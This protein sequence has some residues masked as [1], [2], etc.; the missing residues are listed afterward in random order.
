MADSTN[1]VF[2][3]CILLVALVT[4]GIFLQPNIEEQ[5]APEPEIAWVGIQCDPDGP[6]VVGPIQRRTDDVPCMLHAILEA[7]NRNDEPVYYTEVER[8]SFGDVEVDPDRLRRWRR[9]RWIKAR[10]FTLEGERPYVRLNSED[11]I[12]GF[13]PKEFFRSDW[14]LAWSIP[15]SVDAANDNHLAD[16]SVLERQL[17][18]TQ[19]YHVRVE[20]YRFEDDLLPLQVVRSWGINDLK[21]HFDA[22]PTLEVTQPGPLE[23]AT[24]VFGLTQLELPEDPSPELSEQ[25][26]ELSQRQIAFSKLTLLRDQIRPYRPDT[27]VLA[28]DDGGSVGGDP[29][30][31]VFGWRRS[32]QRPSS[33]R[34]IASRGPGGDSLRGPRVARC[35]RL[36]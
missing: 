17:F 1:R 12:T 36:R 10:W 8:L 35:A 7:R 31:H 16:G 21:E 28:V 9:G 26:D 25:I 20:I 30:G 23:P 34:S 22:F 2:L 24:R 27:G 13:R 18:G 11:G 15:A 14:P 4:V 5:L 32:E 29:M 3:I 19:R 6:A 33:G